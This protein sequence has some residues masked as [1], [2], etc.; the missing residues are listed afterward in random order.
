MRFLKIALTLV[1]LQIGNHAIAADYNNSS[2]EAFHS[3]D[4]DEKLSF[5]HNNR[6]YRVDRGI[7]DKRRAV[8][9]AHYLGFH[10]PHVVLVDDHDITVKGWNSGHPTEV[11]FSRYGYRCPLIDLYTIH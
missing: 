3:S 1:V 8:N 10:Y 9:K 11:I 4:I 2:K 6:P 5:S 7:C